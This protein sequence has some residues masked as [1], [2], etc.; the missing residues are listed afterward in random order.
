VRAYIN[1][2]LLLV[3]GMHFIACQ[4]PQLPKEELQHYLSPASDF[5][6]AV[7]RGNFH[8]RATLLT[9]RYFELRQQLADSAL[10][11]KLV[12]QPALIQI[13]LV[14]EPVENIDLLHTK[15]AQALGYS[16][17]LQRLLFGMGEFIEFETQDGNI[18][19][20]Q[21]YQMERSYGYLHYRTFFLVFPAGYLNSN[22][23][24]FKIRLHEF[25]L[26]TGRAT[27]S[28]KRRLLSQI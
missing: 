10:V 1:I 24:F 7:K 5:T 26:Q 18:F 17:F 4:K 19:P 16:N 21:N 15:E 27:F 20:V 3:T 14:I 23:E 11:D 28:W 25:G 6:Q 2:L 12:Y 8:L 13:L 9:P 22:D